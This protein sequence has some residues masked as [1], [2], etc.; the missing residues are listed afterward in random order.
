MGSDLDLDRDWDW[1]WSRDWWWGS[2]SG[3]GVYASS[4]GAAFVTRRG[5]GET[6]PKKR[7][8]AVRVAVTDGV[9]PLVTLGPWVVLL[10]NATPNIP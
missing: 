5:E 4:P 1:G 9:G 7:N 6:V 2:D 10:N 3:G 8:T